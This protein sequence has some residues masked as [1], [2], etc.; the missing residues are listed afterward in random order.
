MLEGSG[1]AANREQVERRVEFLTDI[2]VWPPEMLQDSQSWLSNFS[3]SDES[4]ELAHALTLLDSFVYFDD[5]AMRA[6]LAAAFRR[7]SQDVVPLHATFAEAIDLWTAFVDSLRVTI[8]TDEHP[9]VSDSGHVVARMVRGALELDTDRILAPEAAVSGLLGGE[10]DRLIL[11]DDFIGSGDQF[12]GT[13]HR[14]YPSVRQSLASAALQVSASVWYCTALATEAGIKRIEMECPGVRVR[15][16]NRVPRDAS[17]VSAT[18]AVWPQSQRVTGPRFVDEVSARVGIAPSG[19]GE[20]DPKGYK[21][22]GLIVA[23]G[24]TVPDAT[25]PLIRW[26]KGAWRPLRRKP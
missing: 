16:G 21:Y 7:L 9:N 22:Q 12:I 3:A 19:G 13:W 23:F 26:E 25:I 20:D 14:V 24:D 5:R 10:F 15:T 1:R 6:L 4:G 2:A 17:V 8:V 11:V 18:S